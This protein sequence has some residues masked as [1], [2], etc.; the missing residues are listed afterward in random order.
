MPSRHAALLRSL[1][2]E[3]LRARLSNEGCL[4]VT[5][6]Q[7][8]GRS[9]AADVLYVPLGLLVADAA[10]TVFVGGELEWDGLVLGPFWLL[11]TFAVLGSYAALCWF[12]SGPLSFSVEANEFRYRGQRYR[13]SD[14]QYVHISSRRGI[15][16]SAENQE[17]ELFGTGAP[18]S[19]EF[20]QRLG[21]IA[22]RINTA[23]FL[24]EQ[25]DAL[26]NANTESLAPHLDTFHEKEEAR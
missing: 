23:V 21:E 11:G 17:V 16:V 8:S 1:S 3:E 9:L 18:L 10:I 19:S 25:L 20:R 14:L 2:P 4:T 15:I 13:L 7:A 6:T 26:D 22:D 12:L 5:R 24:R